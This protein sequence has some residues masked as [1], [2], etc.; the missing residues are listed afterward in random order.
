[1]GSVDKGVLH[2][3]TPLRPRRSHFLQKNQGNL[4][5]FQTFEL[6][7][8]NFSC[9]FLDLMNSYFLYILYIFF[10]KLTIQLNL[11]FQF[12]IECLVL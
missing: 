12:E 6:K 9:H 3:F 11:T 8:D 7:I 2:V 1:M 5:C 4:S 10:S